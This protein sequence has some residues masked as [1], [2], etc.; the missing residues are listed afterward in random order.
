VNDGNLRSL[1]FGK[2]PLE[3]S[4]E[5]WDF[6]GASLMLV[7]NLTLD[8]QTGYTS[9]GGVDIA[10]RTGELAKF[11]LFAGAQVGCSEALAYVR[12]LSFLGA[13]GIDVPFIYMRGY[14]MAKGMY[15]TLTE[16]GRGGLIAYTLM[17]DKNYQVMREWVFNLQPQ[18]F[19]PLLLAL[20]STPAAFSVEATEDTSGENFEVDD[21]HLLQQQAIEL[22]LNWILGRSDATLQFEEAIIC[23]N[24]DGIRPA[25][26]GL[27]YCKNKLR[28]DSFMAE[29]VKTLHRGSEKMRANYR[30]HVIKLGHRLNAH[31]DYQA[32]Y[33]GPAFAPIQKIKTEYKG[34]DID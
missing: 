8:Q 27:T 13:T 6:A 24:R 16:G 25:Q 33:K 5:A 2:L 21:A 32:V 18:A 20:S 12:D 30:D 10:E 28:L 22:C 14:S 23:M 4:A 19:G 34:P 17:Q 11:D 9:I 1:D 15:D 3:L 29:K 31:C 7:R 26:A